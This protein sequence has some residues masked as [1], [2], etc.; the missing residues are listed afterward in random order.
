MSV[1]C[2]SRPNTRRP[3]FGSVSTYGYVPPLPLTDAALRRC[4]DLD[5]GRMSSTDVS[6]APSVSVP[7]VILVLVQMLTGHDD[8]DVGDLRLRVDPEGHAE[9]IE[10]FW[11]KVVRG[12]GK[13]DC[14]IWT[15]AIADDGYGRFW[16]RRGRV[17]RVVR[18]HRYAVAVVMGVVLGPDEVVEHEVCDNPICVRA[19]LDPATGHVWPSTQA[20]N[21]ARM[22]RRARGG[23]AWWQWR[24]TSTDRAGLAARSRAQR[25]AVRGGWDARALRAALEQHESHQICLF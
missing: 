11:A 17:E 23:G 7:G 16:V 2:A 10:R 25:D 9:E 4:P 21:L 12:P 19:E 14:W 24:W 1:T 3:I 6:G 22:G 8:A 18:P 5:L 13:R 15:G 20:A